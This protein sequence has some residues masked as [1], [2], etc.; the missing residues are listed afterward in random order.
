MT[1]RLEIVQLNQLTKEQLAQLASL[2]IGVVE[3]GASIGFLPPL[4]EHEAI[5][6][7]SGVLEPDHVLWIAVLG[8]EIVGSVQLQLAAKRNASHRAEIAK[9]IVAPVHRRKGIARL[10]M[11]AAHE[12]AKQ[13]RR[14]LIVLDT[15]EGDPSNFLY[16]SL[17]YQTVG[18]IPRFAQSASGQLE[19]TVIYYLEL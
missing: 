14:S 16:S 18:R 9:L 10:L 4:T 1:E 13:E 6:Y 17:G 8:E 3:D 15:R 7:W 5:A 19:A 11:Q 2:L 12:R